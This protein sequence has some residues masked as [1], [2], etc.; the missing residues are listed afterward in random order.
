M[1]QGRFLIIDDDSPSRIVVGRALTRLGYAVDAAPSAMEA[2]RLVQQNGAGAYVGV[3][4]DL[5][6]PQINGLE[7]LDWLHGVDASL[8]AAML[9]AQHDVELDNRRSHP[10]VRE[11]L[12]KPV[13]ITR[14]GAVATELAEHTHR[15]RSTVTHAH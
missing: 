7:F 13:D 8:G 3:F 9:T 4:A 12:L 11:V 2:Q 14:L 15:Q 6:M 5:R 1:P 10:T